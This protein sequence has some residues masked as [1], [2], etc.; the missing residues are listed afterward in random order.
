MS[1]IAIIS[2]T[3]A[4]VFIRNTSDS[5]SRLFSE[6]EINPKSIVSVEVTEYKTNKIVVTEDEDFIKQFSFSLKKLKSDNISAS[7]STTERP[8]YVIYILSADFYPG[9]G[10][11]I[12]KWGI[13]YKGRFQSIP[14][15][16]LSSLIKRIEQEVQKGED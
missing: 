8:L 7:T 14:A 4:F 12:Y 15:E 9:G 2:I 13:E 1:I 10:I 16:E 3:S 5:K 11:G 6:E